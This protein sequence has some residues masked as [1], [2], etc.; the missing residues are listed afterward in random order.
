M[1]LAGCEAAIWALIPRLP[2]VERLME[3]RTATAHLPAATLVGQRW[4]CPP[5]TGQQRYLTSNSRRRAC[6][7]DWVAHNRIIVSMD[8][9]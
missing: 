2:A 4:K 1:A 3:L 6:Q 9:W 8:S 7:H 5:E